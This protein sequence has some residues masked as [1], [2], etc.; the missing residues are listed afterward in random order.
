MFTG[1]IKGIGKVTK[2][3]DQKNL[4]SVSISAPSAWK[5]I[6]GESVSVS[7][8]CST[9]ISSKKNVFDVEY[10]KET[11]DI[12]TAKNFTVGAEVNL[13]R[14]LKAGEPFDGHIV[15]GH[16]EDV[17]VVKKVSH[18][19][20]NSVI[21]ISAPKNILKYVI[22]KGSIAIDGVSLTVSKKGS[23]FFEVSLIPYTLSHTTLGK[24]VAGDKVNLETDIIAK[25]AK[26][27]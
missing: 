7:G 17:G 14:S 6:D 20:G 11:L 13:E 27:K 8:I 24:L 22:Y 23:S 4:K 3:S 2:I 9:V 1:I 10:M 12:T 19:A 25:Y 18:G 16:V 21:T 26:T 5:F 15:Y